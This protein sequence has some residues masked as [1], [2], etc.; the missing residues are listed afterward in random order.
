MNPLKR[1]QKIRKRDTVEPLMVQYQCV[2]NDMSP[3]TFNTKASMIEYLQKYV[4]FNNIY[5]LQMYKVT[6]Q[7]LIS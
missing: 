2:I 5:Q 6:I 3:L 4:G 1:L 7:S